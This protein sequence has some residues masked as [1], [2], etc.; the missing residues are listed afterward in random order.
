MYHLQP[1]LA[2]GIKEIALPPV[3]PF[4]M[5]E[6]ALSLTSSKDGYKVSLK[7]IKV[8]GASNFTVQKLT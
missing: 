3:E 4:S 7:D 5:E 6:L 8:Y 2:R 1:Y